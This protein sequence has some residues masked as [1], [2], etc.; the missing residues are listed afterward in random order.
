MSMAYS[1]IGI[2]ISTQKNQGNRGLLPDPTPTIGFLIPEPCYH[3]PNRL[4]PPR[5]NPA[6]NANP[7]GMSHEHQSPNSK[8]ND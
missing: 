2:D 7:P 6:Q 4:P 8:V 3:E 5:G 1:D